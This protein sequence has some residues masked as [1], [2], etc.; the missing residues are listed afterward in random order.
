[1]HPNLSF[2][3][4]KMIFFWEGPSITPDHPRHLL[5]LAPSLLKSNFVLL[6][7]LLVVYFV[8]I[9]FLNLRYVL[10]YL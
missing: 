6:F 10:G 8:C 2:L 5:R 1:M 7:V 4:T 3:G 9:F